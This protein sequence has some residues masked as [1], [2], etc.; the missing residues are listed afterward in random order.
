MNERGSL[1]A[2]PTAMYIPARFGSSGISL[3]INLVKYIVY[4]MKA[5]IHPKPWNIR[6]P[7]SIGR[8]ADFG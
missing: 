8:A 1:P 5:I 6:P 7:I 3:F 4:M 2:G